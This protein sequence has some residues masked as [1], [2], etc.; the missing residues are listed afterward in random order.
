[1]RPRKYPQACE[2]CIQVLS[3]GA[4]RMCLRCLV[5]DVATESSGRAFGGSPVGTES[6]DFEGSD[7]Y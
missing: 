7:R 3:E 2:A 4:S 5:V 1:M 6:V